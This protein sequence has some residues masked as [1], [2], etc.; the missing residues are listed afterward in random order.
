MTSHQHHDIT[1]TVHWSFTVEAIRHRH[2]G[3]KGAFTIEHMLL[4]LT[5]FYLN[6]IYINII[7][8][9]DILF[10][11]VIIEGKLSVERQGWQQQRWWCGQTHASHCS[12]A[13]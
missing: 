10:M 5:F 3:E 8:K 13:S 7:M 4:H 6:L 11:M 2:G 12:P 9:S 1:D